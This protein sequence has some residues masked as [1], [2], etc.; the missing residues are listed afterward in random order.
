ME[1]YHLAQ[2]TSHR[3]PT[4]PIADRHLQAGEVELTTSIPIFPATTAG[5]HGIHTIEEDVATRVTRTADRPIATQIDL[6]RRVMPIVNGIV[7][8]TLIRGGGRAV[9]VQ[10]EAKGE[11]NCESVSARCTDDEANVCAVVDCCARSLIV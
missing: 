8:A 11:R 9:G 5:R 3:D 4:A 6:L 2:Q 7:R 10:I 1:A